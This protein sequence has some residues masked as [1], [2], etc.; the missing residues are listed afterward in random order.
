MKTF[1]DVL[2]VRPDVDA[3]N[4]RTAYRKAA[5]ASH[6]DHH[7]GDPDAAARFRRIA[8]AYDVLRDPERRTAYDRLLETWRNPPKSRRFASGLMRHLV[9]EAIVIA[10]IATVMAGGYALLAANSR[11]PAGEVAGI[12]AREPAQWAA[13]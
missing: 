11:T 4:L 2:D 5:K 12:T 3:E 8:K 6:P 1:Y 13:D 9:S 10:G 7:G